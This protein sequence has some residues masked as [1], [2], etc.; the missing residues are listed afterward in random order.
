MR[1]IDSHIHFWHPDR[2]SYPWLAGVEKLN[3][4]FLRP[5]FA[6]DAEGV[7]IAGI[8]FVEAD[9]LPEQ[10]LEEARWVASL[11][12]APDAIVAFAPLEQGDAVRPHLEQLAQMVKVAGVRRLIQDEGLGFATQPRF[13][14]GVRLL[15]NYDL[16]FDICIRHF[17]LPDVIELVEQCPDVRFVLDHLGKPGIKAREIDAW[18][19]NIGMLAQADNVSCKLS[20]MVTEAG[21]GWTPVDLKPYVDSVVSAF[22]YGR[23]MYGSDWPPVRLAATYSTWWETI[24]QLVSG[25]ATDRQMLFCDNAKAFYRL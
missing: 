19:R 7:E 24:N 9:R 15:A 25:D 17:Q 18:Q 23:L 21:A 8:V 22:G 13:V 6:A 4:P 5:D 11:E 10:G 1:I 3:R 14:E 12:N 2:F 16:S 20:G